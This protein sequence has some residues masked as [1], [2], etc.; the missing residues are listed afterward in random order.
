MT[1]I[2]YIQILKTYKIKEDRYG[3]W[4]EIIFLN[5]ILGK[6]FFTSIIFLSIF[7]DIFE[8]INFI[9]KTW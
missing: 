4:F 6:T 1:S 2:I 3:E 8:Y 9:G 7:T 5:I